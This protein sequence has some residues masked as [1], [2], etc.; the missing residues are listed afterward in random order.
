MKEPENSIRINNQ[1]AI[2]RQIFWWTMFVGSCVAVYGLD[3]DRMARLYV[4]PDYS[5]ELCVFSWFDMILMFLAIMEVFFI[6]DN[7]TILLFSDIYL[8]P[9]FFISQVPLV[10]ES[11]IFGLFYDAYGQKIIGL[12]IFIVWQKVG[13]HLKRLVWRESAW[14]QEPLI[15]LLLSL[16]ALYLKV[17]DRIMLFGNYVFWNGL[18]FDIRTLNAR[19]QSFFVRYAWRPAIDQGLSSYIPSI[20]VIH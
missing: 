17:H 19:D 5:G 2:L 11:G 6:T 13:V 15:I 14:Q 12:L 16:V 8:V 18:L 3:L 20:S 1:D 9:A 7:E 10:K 4:L